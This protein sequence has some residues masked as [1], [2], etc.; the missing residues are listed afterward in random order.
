VFSGTVTETF[1]T[2]Y[3]SPL[4][5]DFLNAPAQRFGLIMNGDGTN[6]KVYFDNIIINGVPEPASLA[7]LGLA[8]PA[9]LAVRRRTRK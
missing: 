5:A 9:L 7:M 3:G 8:V 2:K 6:V 1:T 4:A